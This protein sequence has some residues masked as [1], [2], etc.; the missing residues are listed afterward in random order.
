MATYTHKQ[1]GAVL[2]LIVIGMLVLIMAAGLAFSA[3]LSYMIKAKLNAATDSAALAGAR[4]TSLG[5]DQATQT[6]NAKAAATR[7]FNANFPAGYLGSTATLGDTQVSYSG[8][9]VTVRSRPRPPCRLRC[10]APT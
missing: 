5:G 3:G 8:G 10:S 2:P 6:A 1:R 7:F 9:Q 4:A